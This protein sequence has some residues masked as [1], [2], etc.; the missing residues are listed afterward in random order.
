MS[1]YTLPDLDWDYGALEPHISGAINELHHDKHHATYVKG[2]NDAVAK[3]EEARVEGRPLDDPAQRKELGFQPG[4][5][6]QPQ[7]CGGRSCPPTAVTSRPVIWPPPSTTRSGRSTNSALSSP[8]RRPTACR[9]PAGPRWLG[10]PRRQAADI[11]GVRPPDQFPARPGSDLAARHVGARFLLGLQE[12]Q[13]GLYQGVL[14]CDELG[15][16]AIPL[17]AAATSK[18]KGLIS[19]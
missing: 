10:Q 7:W 18:A 3:L 15:R 13:S 5:P 9:A 1:D 14:E 12:R 11:P 17:Q 8:R 6:R 19:A 16:R 2:A 4:R